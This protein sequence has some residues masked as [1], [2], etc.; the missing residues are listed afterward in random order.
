MGEQKTDLLAEA[1]CNRQQQDTLYYEPKQIQW[2]HCRFQHCIQTIETQLRENDGSLVELDQ[3]KTFIHL[4]QTGVNVRVH[5]K[6]P[7]I[8]QHEFHTLS[9]TDDWWKYN[10]LPHTGHAGKRIKR[11]CDF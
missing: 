6:I 9:I 11:R 4:F 10:T 1:H 2:V 7:N 5:H 8:P 3:G